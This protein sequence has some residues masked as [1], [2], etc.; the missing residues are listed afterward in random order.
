MLL[1]MITP[2]GVEGSALTHLQ[3][4]GLHLDDELAGVGVLR[5]GVQVVDCRDLLLCSATGKGIS[6][7]PNDSGDGGA[8]ASA[9]LLNV[10]G[11]ARA[12][13]RRRRCDQIA[14]V[15]HRRRPPLGPRSGPARTGKRGQRG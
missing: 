1:K 8:A 7:W 11:E 14:A 4:D 5:A 10:S 6:L 13:N 2:P 15:F 12:V 9:G 3:D